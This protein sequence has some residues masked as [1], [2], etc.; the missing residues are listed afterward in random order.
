MDRGD[1]PGATA[2]ATWRS[3]STDP[4]AERTGQAADHRPRLGTDRIDLYL[5]HRPDPSTPIAETLDA[6]AL[7]VKAGKVR[8]IGCSNFTAAQLRE[9]DAA[10]G[11]G[12]R[13]VCVQNHYNLLRRDDEADV[14]PLCRDLGVAYLPYF[15]LASGVL[16]GKYVRGEKPPVGTRLERWGD[17]AARALNDTTF[18]KVEALAAWAAKHDHTVLDVAFAWLIAQ[19]EVSSVIAGATTPGQVTANAAA[20]RW[21]LS[22]QQVDEINALT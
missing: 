13:F 9:A 8:E 17:R 5:L 22:R 14:M 21:T 19:P 4:A 12:P 18:D 1:P 11:D 2:A 7:A 10:A 6:L 20:G 16:T 3:A 15:P